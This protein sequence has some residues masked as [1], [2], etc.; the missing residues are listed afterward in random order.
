MR[1]VCYEV[2]TSR[3]I[4]KLMPRDYWLTEAHSNLRNT[5]IARR[6]VLSLVLGAFVRSGARGQFIPD[7]PVAIHAA[8][9]STPVRKGPIEGPGQGLGSTPPAPLPPRPPTEHR[10]PQS[11][12]PPPTPPPPVD[13]PPASAAVEQTSQGSRRPIE[14]DAGF[15]ALGDGFTGHE[16]PSAGT[17]AEATAVPRTAARGG[18]D[19]SI[20]VGPNHIFEI[21]NGNMAVFTKKGKKYASTGKTAIRPR[22]QQHRVRRFR[23]ALRGRQQQRFGR[24]V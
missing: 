9:E 4:E 21:L 8:V 20:A 18:I 12:G 15:D 3:D 2:K 17:S 13:V 14:P 1:R 6:L 19:I 24:A 5:A 7:K 22:S 10:P 23:R 11:G 16:L